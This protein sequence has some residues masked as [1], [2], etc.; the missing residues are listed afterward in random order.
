MLSDDSHFLKSVG[1]EQ[2]TISLRISKRTYI[3]CGETGN[4]EGYQVVLDTIYSSM[5]GADT[6][7]VL[8]VLL[9]IVMVVMLKYTILVL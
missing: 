8:D 7:H 4:F 2:Q 9:I 6:L 5:G 1:L 3:A